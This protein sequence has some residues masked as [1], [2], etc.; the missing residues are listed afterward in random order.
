MQLLTSVG[1]SQSGLSGGETQR[2]I[3]ARAL[4]R[5][6]RIMLLDEATSLLDTKSQANIMNTLSNMPMT[7]I[8]I[9]HRLSTL[10]EADRIYVMKAG[11]FVEQGTYQELIAANGFFR[12]LVRRQEYS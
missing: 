4:M 1:G 3:I 6:P 2:I 10:R 9:A 8:I 12:E 5:N 11:K 7:R